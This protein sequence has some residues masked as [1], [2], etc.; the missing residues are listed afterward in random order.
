MTL[1]PED[2]RA[3]I[4]YESPSQYTTREQAMLQ[5]GTFKEFNDVI[6]RGIVRSLGIPAR[7]LHGDSN[8][9]FQRHPLG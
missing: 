1:L 5:H 9:S 7:F 2:S 3:M 8:Y 4:V 6:M